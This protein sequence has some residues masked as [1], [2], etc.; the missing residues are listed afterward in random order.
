MAFNP[1]VPQGTDKLSNSQSDI[2]ANFQAL[3]PFGFGYA[4]FSLQGSIPSIPTGDNGMYTFLYSQTS[5]NELYITKQSLDA[6]TDIPFAASSMSNTAMASCTNGWSYLPSG[7]LVKWGTYQ[8][9]NGSIAVVP[10]NVLSGGPNYNVIFQTY[11][12]PS[13]T[14]S[15]SNSASIPVYVP[16]S[17]TLAGNFQLFVTNYNASSY[18][19]YLI[20]GV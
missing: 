13:W 17:G 12:T 6:P 7:I 16:G 1:N 10:V 19:N 18:V 4:D 9:S 5:T 8:P 14:G 11:V 15:A 3:A 2:L 20:I